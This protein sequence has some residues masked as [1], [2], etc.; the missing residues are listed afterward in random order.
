MSA[1][2]PKIEASQSFLNQSADLAATTVFTPSVDGMYRV[3]AYVRSV[4]GTGGA[5]ARI[6]WTDEAGTTSTGLN[7]AGSPGQCTVPMKALAGTPITIQASIYSSCTYSL[8]VVVES[9]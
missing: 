8:Y 4:S 5:A 3:S 7:L 2:V 6:G 9:L 1:Q